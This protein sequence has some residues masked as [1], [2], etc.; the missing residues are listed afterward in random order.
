M[1]RTVFAALGSAVI[2]IG[3]CVLLNPAGAQGTELRGQS[4]H[5]QLNEPGD[6]SLDMADVRLSGEV[7]GRTH[8]QTAQLQI[9][10]FQTERLEARSEATILSGE[11]LGRS[12]IQTR[13]FSS[14]ALVRDRLTVSTT[15]LD[16]G[17]QALSHLQVNMVDG[18]FTGAFQSITMRGNDVTFTPTSTLAGAL[19]ISARDLALSGLFQDDV[20][21]SV[22]SLSFTGTAERGLYVNAHPGVTPAPSIDGVVRIDGQV[23]GAVRICALKVELS[24]RFGSIVEVSADTA[25][26]VRDDA[27]EADIRF[28]QRRDGRCVFD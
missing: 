25:P 19:D 28:T 23:S 15:D 2:A 17:G 14:S 10:D 21:S 13:Q 26:T 16:F 22:R 3:A 18:R 5:A 12:H 6:L 27:L 1:N 7:G 24:G 8:V 11:L 20:V 9:S 4:F